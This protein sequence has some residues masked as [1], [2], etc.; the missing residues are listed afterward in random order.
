MKICSKCNTENKDENIYCSGCGSVL[1][2]NAADISSQQVA[3]FHQREKKPFTFYDICT[4]FSFVA[5]IMGCF[6]IWLIFEPSAIIT[7]LI[8]FKK[9]SRYKPLAVSAI[10]IAIIGF[11]IQLFITLYQNHIIDEWMV[12]GIFH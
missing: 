7:A 10:I 2:N 9:G 11:I 12:K 8:G 5:S 1:I 3:Q 4:L 6:C